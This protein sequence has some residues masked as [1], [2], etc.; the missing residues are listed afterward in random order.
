LKS[1]EDV[2]KMLSIPYKPYKPDISSYAV[3]EEKLGNN[4][5]I[6]PN[7]GDPLLYVAEMFGFTNFTVYSVTHK[8]MIA[9]L[10]EIMAERVYNY[11][12][13][14]LE[15]NIKGVYR[16]VGPEYATPPYLSPEYFRDFVVKYDTGLIELIHKY[17]AVARVHSHGKV[18]RLLEYFRDMG[19]DALD[20]VEAPPAGDVLLRDVKKSIGKEV[21]LIGNL[22]LSD[23]ETL[24]ISDIE[25]MVKYTLNEGMPGGR[26]I[27]M[28]TAAPINEPISDKTRKNYHA[29][30]E[31]ALRY[32]EY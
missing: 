11:L 13:Y 10:L 32:G 15:N 17:G 30:I 28:P 18:G 1:E 31:T 7:L 24:E 14:L 21:C 26:F 4:G 8:E 22:Q 25:E 9:E 23:L 3:I 2:E 19:A 29:F 6:M 27:L 20:P 5:V 16:I 12:K